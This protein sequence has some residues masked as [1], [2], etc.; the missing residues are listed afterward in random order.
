[1]RIILVRVKEHSDLQ[2]LLIGLI[3]QA[4]WSVVGSVSDPIRRFDYYEV[5]LRDLNPETTNGQDMVYTYE[6]GSLEKV[7][8]G[9]P[10]AVILT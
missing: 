4:G 6:R 10:D 3:E 1:M 8:H 2:P 7:I 5:A 9:I